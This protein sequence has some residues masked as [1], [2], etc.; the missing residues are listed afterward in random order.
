VRHLIDSGD[1]LRGADRAS[2]PASP[3]SNWSGIAVAA[4]GR[5]GLRPSPQG[6]KRSPRRPDHRSGDDHAVLEGRSG[7][8]GR[9]PDRPRAGCAQQ[10]LLF[11]RQGH[12]A[13]DHLRCVPAGRAG[14]AEADRPGQEAQAQ[15]SHREVLLCLG[16]PQRDLSRAGGGKG[17][18]RGGEPNHHPVPR[19][20]GGFRQAA[21]ERRSRGRAHGAG[22]PPPCRRS[23]SSRARKCSC[24]SRRATTRAWS[25]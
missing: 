15:A 25:R 11:Q 2:R 6:R 23:T 5:P 18:H 14:A 16:Q 7:P 12:A 17:R 21:L 20:A 13:W 4:R 3:G 1:G 9:A 22:L 19:D 24:A 10:D 8:D